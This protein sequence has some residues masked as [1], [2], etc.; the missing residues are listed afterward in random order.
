VPRLPDAQRHRPRLLPTFATRAAVRITGN[1]RAWRV[2]G[3]SGNAKS[4]CFC[5]ICGAP[6]YL[7]FAA[8]PEAIAVHAGSL[9]ESERFRPTVVT[10]GIRALAWDRMDPALTTFERMPDG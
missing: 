10:Y 7:T 8:M 2:T 1:A 5:P 4:H 6:V 9:D 3:D